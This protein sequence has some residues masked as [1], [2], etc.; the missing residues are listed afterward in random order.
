MRLLALDLIALWASLLSFVTCSQWRVLKL[1]YG[2]V[3]VPAV[4]K[5]KKSPTK[6]VLSPA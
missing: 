1:G 6:D 2:D 4:E 3:S 5:V